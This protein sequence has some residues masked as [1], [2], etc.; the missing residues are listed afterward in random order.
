M[1]TNT[2][3]SAE[4]ISSE[5][6]SLQRRVKSLQ[7][8]VRLADLQ[9]RVE[10]LETN[11]AALGNRVEDLRT[12]GYLFEKNLE[13]QAKEQASQWA[14]IRP[15]VQ[16]HLR[17]QTRLLEQDLRPIETEMTRLAARSRNP[18]A[19]KS[20]L[21]RLEPKVD[22]LE[23]KASAASNSISGLFDQYA[24]QVSQF[25]TRLDKIDWMLTQ[26]SEATFDLLPTEGGIAAVKATWIKGRKERDEDPKGLLYLTD[27]RVIFEQKQEI[28]TKKVLFVTTDKEM[29]QEHLFDV[30]V[31]MI[32]K[33]KAF[34]KGF[35]GKEDHLEVTFESGAP[36]SSAH[37]HI[38]GQDSDYWQ[39]LIGRVKEK[40]FDKDRAVEIDQEQ[41]DKVRAVPSNCPSCG[42][43]ITETVLRGMETLSCQFCGHVIRL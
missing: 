38:F 13:H 15:N 27:Q 22:M 9:D 1:A 12:R 23:G 18:V 3:S 11:S 7:S 31:A 40:E 8:Q 5:I 21:Q 29:V 20:L 30:P 16:Q 32:A 6:N 24:N 41:V 35:L 2:S 17:R 28:A 10:D 37:F 34:E 36:L 39:G 26:L 19:A 25:S 33:V 43:P 14:K 4:Q 42:A